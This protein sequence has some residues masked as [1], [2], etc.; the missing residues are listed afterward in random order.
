[1]ISRYLTLSKIPVNQMTLFSEI[2]TLV[3]FLTKTV[4]SNLPSVSGKVRIF[5]FFNLKFEIETREI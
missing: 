2:Q 4:D 1:M 5:R 3:V